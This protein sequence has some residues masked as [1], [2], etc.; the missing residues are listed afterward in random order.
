MSVLINFKICDNAEECSGI[1]V[2]PTGALYWDKDKQTVNIDNSKCITCGACENACE[3]G[4]IRVAKTKEEHKKIKKE[5][6]EDPRKAN[7]LLIDR[8]GAQPIEPVF[9]IKYGFEQEILRSNKLTVVEL[10]SDDSVHCLLRSIPIKE[11]FK[12]LDLKY[13][14]IEITEDLRKCYKI[15][16]L[17]SLLFFKNGKLIGKIEGYYESKEKLKEKIDKII[18]KT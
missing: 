16:K 17:P 18:F 12:N 4:A 9:Q 7:D 1:D 11:L 5:I 15:K 6:D 3:V 14:K 8:Y 10:F 13:K 2:C